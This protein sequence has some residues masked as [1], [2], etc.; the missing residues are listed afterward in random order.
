M[1][2]PVFDPAKLVDFI[3]ELHEQGFVISTEQYSAAQDLLITLAAQGRMPANPQSLSSWLAPI[4]C[5]S[6]EEQ[7]IF[8]EQFK[9]WLKRQPKSDEVEQEQIRSNQIVRRAT[10]T[11]TA[12]QRGDSKPEGVKRSRRRFRLQ[13]LIK[14]SIRVIIPAAI[15]FAI[16][17]FIQAPNNLT[18]YI[19]N[20]S[21]KPIRNAVITA[22]D[23]AVRSNERGLFSLK[24]HSK[25]LPI[26]ISVS[27]E[28]YKSVDVNFDSTTQ[29]PLSITLEY[30]GSPDQQPEIPPVP[31][32]GN[33]NQNGADTIPPL[34]NSNINPG[35]TPNPTTQEQFLR[36]R[37]KSYRDYFKLG[38]V[39]AMLLPF[40]IF[41]LWRI[42][43]LHHLQLMRQSTDEDY[44]L[45]SL[46]V[47]GTADQIFRGQA[48]RRAAQELR[49]HRQFESDE[50]DPHLTINATIRRG[51]LFTPIYGLRQKQPEYLAL[52][53]RAGFEDQQQQMEDAL[54]NRLV[55]E[56]VIIDRYYFHGS[57][58]VCRK[59]D[60]K[61]SHIDLQELIAL[62]PNR[63]LLLFSDGKWLIN[64]FTA[65]PQGWLDMLANWPVRVLLTPQR[66]PYLGYQ[67]SLLSDQG[68]III[69]ASED[70][71]AALIEIIRA[72][73][74]PKLDKDN[75]SR[76]FPE[77]LYERPGRWLE[78]HEPSYTDANQLCFQ[79]RRFLGDKG[80]CLLGACA[81]YPT[82]YW[83]LTLHLAHSL[84]LS[85][86][87]EDRLWSLVRLPWFRYGSMPDWLRLQLISALPKEYEERTRQVLMKLLK[88]SFEKSGGRN[89]ELPYVAGDA[90]NAD[91]R[92]SKGLWSGFIKKVRAWHLKQLW[93]DLIRS[94]SKQ[95]AL[96]DYVFLT[97]MSGRRPRKL[98]LNV[99]D[100]LRFVLYPEGQ[101]ILGLRFMVGLLLTLLCSAFIFVVLSAQNQSYEALQALLTIKSQAYSVA[102]SPNGEMLA[103]SSANAINLWNLS[104]GNEITPPK[105]HSSTVYS[106]AFSPDGKMLASGSWDNTIK[107]WGLSTGNELATLQRHSNVVYSVAFSPD[108][109][110][111]AS[112]SADNTIKLWDVN[113]GNEIMTLKGH[114]ST[115]Y[116]VAFSPDGKMLA[117]GSWDRTIKLWDVNT[118]NEIMTLMGHS[119][120]VRCVAFSP[121]GK[122]IASGSLDKTVRLWDSRTG[123]QLNSFK[124]NSNPSYSVKFSPDGKMLAGDSQIWDL[125]T[126]NE[127]ARLNAGSTIF[128]SS[129]FSP[130][131][132]ALAINST[133]G[134]ITL[135]DLTGIVE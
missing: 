22:D 110:M 135:W 112:G 8:Y 67:E 120:C 61:A 119:E 108:G 64:A 93:K 28:G 45:E 3:H 51:G 88:S 29:L 16:Y 68:F 132:K 73:K 100:T 114:S 24:Y 98:S 76:P 95:S 113:T 66:P 58:L 41:G 82:L 75:Q 25:D 101:A 128:I 85:D 23:Q 81:V 74:P 92:G 77:M 21:K 87:L 38:P 65:E 84:S 5:T 78:N 80:Y 97:F 36:R 69:P 49:R 39:A 130:D 11:T 37:S 70:G 10:F 106:V 54:I 126:G 20:E 90:T 56:G 15:I 60:P 50:I 111:L 118:G 89:F 103:S 12:L 124:G 43:N 72:N 59:K 46:T 131:S 26:I 30:T 40:L 1:T 44:L 79:L 9:E 83:Q 48:L 91:A 116:S 117:S 27:R 104:T 63:H 107:L 71:L 102:F 6:P 2:F 42:Y 99:P 94:Q 17:L 7:R 122:V 35:P 127:L 109:K 19:L 52:I 86:D 105:R 47:K 129:V 115:V 31:G 34:G 14:Y 13:S 123:K 57:P 62:Y 55:N 53:E 33:R 134:T 96:R 121:D 18:G 125:S 4:L 133:D 32:N